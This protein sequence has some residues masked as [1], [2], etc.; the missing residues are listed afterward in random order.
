[1]RWN[2]LLLLIPAFSASLLAQEVP[3]RSA[4]VPPARNP[5]VATNGEASAQKADYHFNLN[6][7]PRLRASYDSLERVDRSQRV[8]IAR[9]QAM[10]EEARHKIKPAPAE[11][12]RAMPPLPQGYVIGFV[13]GYCVV[14]DP[15]TF[16][17]AEAID[18]L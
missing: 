3:D 2:C 10:P 17:V 11:L 1:M 12:I 8:A 13:D 15:N 9:Q 16:F 4:D 7:R 6:D 5:R 18:L 14:Y